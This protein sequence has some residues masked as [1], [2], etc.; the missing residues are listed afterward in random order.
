ML[1]PLGAKGGPI[2]PLGL[3]SLQML[4]VSAAG[5]TGD[6]RRLHAVHR[7]CRTGDSRERAPED[8]VG[9]GRGCCYFVY[10]T[11]GHLAVRVEMGDG[12]YA[13]GRVSEAIRKG[14]RR[15]A[16]DA[17]IAVGGT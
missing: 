5:L 11:R 17:A 4:V 1:F 3:V 15:E 14:G 13:R 10:G 9:L 2:G 12:V 8:F 7:A 16:G 6:K